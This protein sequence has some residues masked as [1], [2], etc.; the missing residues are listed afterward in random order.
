MIRN[1]MQITINLAIDS[2]QLPTVHVRQEV[3]SQ[4]PT[5]KGRRE[6]RQEDT[7]D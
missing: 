1:H 4:R 5:L 7:I 3:V 2:D 6:I